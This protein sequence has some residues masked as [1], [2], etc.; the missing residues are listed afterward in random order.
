MLK[1]ITI[2]FLALI[3]LLALGLLSYGWY[4]STHIEQR[5]SVRRWSVPSKVYSD[6]TLLYPGQRINPDLLKDNGSPGLP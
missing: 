6:T 4:L 3:L 2:I 5:F 1:K